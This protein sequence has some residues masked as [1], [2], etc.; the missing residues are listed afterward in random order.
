MTKPK[1]IKPGLVSSINAS[2]TIQEITAILSKTNLKSAT[3][4]K[5]MMSFIIIEEKIET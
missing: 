4:K 2:Y 3:V 1:E 5:T